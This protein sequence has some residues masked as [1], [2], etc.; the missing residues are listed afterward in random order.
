MAGLPIAIVDDEAIVLDAVV[1]VLR[2]ALDVEVRGFT[3]GPDAIA[4]ARENELGLAVLDVEMAPL[5]GLQVAQSLRKLWPTL[6]V[7]FLTGSIQENSETIV[8]G[9]GAVAQYRKP[10]TSAELIA[11]VQGRRR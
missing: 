7:I 9:I 11:A 1:R 5:N 10:L 3:H 6:P 8:P 2:S 4:F